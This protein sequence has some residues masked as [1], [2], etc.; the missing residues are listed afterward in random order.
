M[1][2]GEGKRPPLDQGFFRNTIGD[3][4]NDL[5]P[6]TDYMSSHY[7]MDL[8]TPRSDSLERVMAAVYTDVFGGGLE[9]EAFRAFMTLIK[10][11]LL[12][13]FFTTKTLSTNPPRGVFSLFRP[14]L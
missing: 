8:L 6:V 14:P 9:R 12:R 4:Q 7:G 10:V 5:E 11:F 1:A 13:L 3:Y 2:R